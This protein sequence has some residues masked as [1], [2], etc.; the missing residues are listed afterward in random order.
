MKKLLALCVLLSQVAVAQTYDYSNKWGFGGSYGYNT[1]VFGNI[2]NEV[3]DGDETWGF[4]VRYHLNKSSG[5]ELAYTKHELSDTPITLQV[6]DLTWFKRLA[7]T[8]RLTPVIGAG[9]GVVDITDYAP[10]SLKLGIKLRGG[11]EYALMECL[12]LGLNVDY[13]HVN[14]MLFSDNL[15]TR[16]AH[17]LAGRVGLTYYFGAHSKAHEKAAPVAATAPVA[18]AVTE[19]DSDKDG[20]MDSKDKCPTTAVGVAV[21]AYG[22][23]QAEKA[24][25]KLN[26]QFASGKSELNKSYDSDLKEIADFM[27][28]HPTTKVQIQ[29]HTDNTGSKALNKKLSG[30]RADAVKNYL[31]NTLGADASRLESVGHGDEMPVADNST[32]TGRQENRRVIAVITE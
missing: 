29:G 9:L 30:S 3:A 16:N 15:P 7:P 22:C 13:Q 32:V 4:H 11:L 10:N 31:V 19:M 26:V 18:A 20:V 27:K 21:N 14:K 8:S 6:T 24:T 1:P 2:T 5:L 12:S 17:V 28:S 25:V 23:A